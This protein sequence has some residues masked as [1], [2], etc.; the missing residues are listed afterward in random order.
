MRRALPQQF[1][2]EA[3][4]LARRGRVLPYPNPWV[5]CVIVKRGRAIGRGWHL[6][7]GTEHAEIMALGQAGEGARGATMYVTLEPCCHWGRTPPC[8]DAILRAGI[9]EVFYALHDPNPEVAGRGERLLRAGGVQVHAGLCAEPAT[10]L[11]EVYLKYCA[12]G[13]P[14]VAAK[15]ATTLDG[16]TATRT[17]E[18]KWITDAAARRRARELRLEHS[19]VLVGVNTV[20]ADDPNLGPRRGRRFEP[21]RVILDSRLRT[22]PGSQVVRSGK[23]I[24]TATTRASAA[25]ERRLQRAGAQVWRFPGRR[26][27]LRPL[28]R[29][30]AGEGILSVLVEGGSETLGSFFDA[31]LVDRVHWFVAPIIVG[32]SQSLCAVGG[33]GAARLREAWRLRNL[34]ITPVGSCWLF[35]GQ[36]SRWARA[37]E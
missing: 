37:P 31:E 8:T 1:M 14:F 23:C 9:R 36:A 19:A 5:G 26:V 15:V 22:P 10:A 28:L 12:T 7:A 6:G 4:R 17:R 24:I 29:R 33:R 3:L 13:L 18:S 35:S 2:Q 25:A 20:L 32:S 11:N 16:K 34:K 30:L 27:P 21:W